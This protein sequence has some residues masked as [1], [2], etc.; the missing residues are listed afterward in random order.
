MAERSTVIVLTGW[1]A[2]AQ[3][4]TPIRRG[5]ARSSRPVRGSARCMPRPS[6]RK[7]AVYR[8]SDAVQAAIERGA[9]LGVARADTAVANAGLITARARP[10]PALSGELQQ[11]RSELSRRASTSRSIFRWLRQMRMRAA[12]FGLQ[13][14]QLRYQLARATDRAG[15]RHDVHARHRGA[16]T[17][18]AVAPQRA[19]RRQPAAHGRAA[20]RRRR[21]ERHGR[22][23]GARERRP[24]G[25]RRGGRFA[26]RDLRAAR[27][28]G[29]ARHVG[30]TTRD[31]GDGFARRAARGAPLPGRTL[32]EAAAGLSLESATLNATS[33][34]PLDLVAPSISLG[35]ETA[36]L[37]NRDFCRRSALASACRCSIAI[38]AAIAQAEAERAR[39][40]AEL[41]LAQV[42]ARNAD[43]ARAARAR[44]RARPRRARPRWS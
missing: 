42:E 41:A 39:A 29:G 11:V 21:R 2:S 10:N 44:E 28:P 1:L 35:F 7:L 23:A 8:R 32:G 16:R 15:R 17:A 33:S 43:R 18:R 26:R 6:L 5:H 9:R 31:S 12:E 20:P 36:I 3:R 27:S 38:A 25:E 13:A 40:A 19:R 34:A 4:F 30:R 14:A 24:A 37:I 22:R